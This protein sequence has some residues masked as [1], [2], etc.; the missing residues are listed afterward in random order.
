MTASGPTSSLRVDTDTS[1]ATDTVVAIIG[2]GVAGLTAAWQL[3]TAGQRVTLFEARSRLGGRVL[4]AP[5]APRTDHPWIDLGP[6]WFW[7]H[8]QHI[9]GLVAHFG[10][11]VFEQHRNGTAM[12]DAGDGRAPESFD[13]SGQTDASL[14]LAG[15]MAALTRAL[16]QAS[17]TAPQPV[18]VHLDAAVHTLELRPT[19]VVINGNGFS[20]TAGRVIMAVPPRAVARD[21][22]FAPPLSDAMH[23][24]LA[25][26]VTWMGHAMKCVVT[27]HAPFWRDLGHSG[28]AVSWGG[29]LQEIHDACMPPSDHTP[30]GYALMGFVAPRS[31][32]AARGF[33]DASPEARRAAVLVQLARLFGEE[34]HGAVDYAEYDWAHDP[35]SCGPND[36]LPPGAH[37]EY[38]HPLFNGDAGDVSGASWNGRLFWAGTETSD[39]GGGYL[40]GAVASGLRAAQLVIAAGN[41]P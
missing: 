2:G 4:T 25:E 21:I 27:Y 29:P 1:N 14:R 8:Q 37:P 35:L 39:I 16:Q 11:P 28:Y 6:A 18:A 22:A 12:Y 15:G 40:D 20:G 26:T 23:A 9:R 3:A 5:A 32:A 13:A 17:Q 10:L 34:A 7:P 41:E 19:G 38:G 24:A 31:N 36:D 30:A 33:R